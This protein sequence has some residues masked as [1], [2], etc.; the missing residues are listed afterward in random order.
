MKLVSFLLSLFLLFFSLVFSEKKSSDY[1]IYADEIEKKFI[2]EMKEKYDCVCIGSGGSMPQLVES[3]NVVFALTH[4]ATI[5]EARTLE[6]SAIERLVEM[7]NEDER[8]RPYLAEFPFPAHRVEIAFSFYAPYGGPF[9]DGSLTRISQIRG[10]ISY[11]TRHAMKGDYSCLLEESYEEAKKIV[12]SSPALNHSIHQEKAHEPI[13]DA[14]FSAYLKRMLKE[15]DLE[16]ERIG[17]KLTDGVEEVVARLI[18]FHPTRIDKARELQVV[19]TEKLLD[20]IN[21]SEQLRPYIKD[22]PISLD[23]L[24]VVV[25][26]RKPNYFSYYDGTLNS[27]CRE[28]DKV[29]YLVTPQYDKDPRGQNI[30]KD[31]PVFATESYQDC[32]KRIQKSSRGKKLR[33]K[34]RD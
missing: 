31:P 11:R 21:S 33:I 22:Y 7:L 9:M 30:S 17:G 4:R 15:C 26:F 32:V 10:K 27:V 23:K 19:A 13:I 6:V 16:C 14:I 25:L 2:Q 5:E 20:A 28:G 18:Y 29:T 12:E 34:W 1:I 24:K 8:I 3:I